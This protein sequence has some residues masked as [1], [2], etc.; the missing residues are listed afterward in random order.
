[1]LLLARMFILRLTQKNISRSNSHTNMP[2]KILFF[3]VAAGA[4]L[5]QQ[6]IEIPRNTNQE[7]YRR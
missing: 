6:V 2:Q 4:A 7:K 3:G 5:D 1:M